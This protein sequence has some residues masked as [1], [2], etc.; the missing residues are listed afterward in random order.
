[1]RKKFEKN[2]E[3]FRIFT[4]FWQLTQE[5]YEPE[6]SDEYWEKLIDALNWFEG[7]HKGNKLCKHMIILLFSYLHDKYKKEDMAEYLILL[8]K[9]RFAYKEF[10]DKADAKDKQFLDETLAANNGTTEAEL[11]K[12][13]IRQHA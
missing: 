2:D 1:M 12:T 5:F 9:V 3:E 6:E 7:K 10:L 11:L 4:E 8:K 13:I